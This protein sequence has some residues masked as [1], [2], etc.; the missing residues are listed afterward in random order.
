[1]ESHKDN[2]FLH[3]VIAAVIVVISVV[4]GGTIYNINDRTLMSKNIEQAI[5]KGI[6]PLSVK[7][8]YQTSVDPMCIS[9]SMKK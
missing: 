9:F 5:A 2:T 3:F 1:M 7:C 6:D 8:A 4:V